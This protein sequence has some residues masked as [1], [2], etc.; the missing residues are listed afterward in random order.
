MAK[1]EP[2]TVYYVVLPSGTR[3]GPYHDKKFAESIARELTPNNQLAKDRTAIQT[4]D[5]Q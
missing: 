4:E 1:V 5:Q 2:V 3:S